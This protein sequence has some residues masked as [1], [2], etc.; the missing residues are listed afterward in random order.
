MKDLA[1]P[2][3]LP[4]RCH[5]C[6][7]TCFDAS[8]ERGGGGQSLLPIKFSSN[9]LAV[10]PS[11]TWKT[12]LRTP[13]RMWTLGVCQ[14]L[15]SEAISPCHGGPHKGGNM[16]AC[17]AHSRGYCC[18]GDL[19]DRVGTARKAATAFSSR[20]SHSFVPRHRKGFLTLVQSL[21]K[22]VVR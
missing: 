12:V 3:R 10:G 16:L 5:S 22:V 4:I 2:F 18:A 20:L 6:L 21:A 9:S 15:L 11:Q 14:A 19:H 8:G 1:A 13:Q 17:S 7:V